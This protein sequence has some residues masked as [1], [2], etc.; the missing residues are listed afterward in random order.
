MGL[1]LYGNLHPV[2]TAMPPKPFD[3][4][5]VEK[6]GA[7]L[8]LDA[9]AS[10]DD[11]KVLIKARAILE[12]GQYVIFDRRTRNKIT[13]AAGDPNAK[14]PQFRV[15]LVDD[16]ASL[17]ITMTAILKNH[18]FEVY[19]ADSVGEALSQIEA[20][21]FDV[22]LSDLN[23]HHESDGFEVL[24]AMREAQP[25]CARFILTGYP[26]FESAIEGI[27]SQVDDYFSKPVE[28][29]VL[30]DRIREVLHRR[31]QQLD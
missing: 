17:R 20:H 6:D 23:I 5:V 8:W 18:G 15:L 27:K 3:I 12:P 1:P 9:A 2:V 19:T 26:A 28:V 10:L 14:Q 16:E 4:L 13:F 11:A 24:N 30:I 7:A 22:L 31:A 25:N 29:S 21:R